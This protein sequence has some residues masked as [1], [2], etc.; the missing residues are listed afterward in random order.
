MVAACAAGRHDNVAKA[1]AA[2]PTAHLALVMIVR[3]RSPPAPRA[4]TGAPSGANYHGSIVTRLRAP[5][6]RDEELLAAESPAVASLDSDQARLARAHSEMKAG[7]DA[8]AGLGPAVSLFGSAR[9]PPDHPDYELALRTARLLGEAGYAVIT[10]GGPGIME[11]GNRGAR[12]AG[13]RSVGLN[14]E[15]PFEQDSNP[16][17]D[18]QLTF[19]YFFTRKLMF[20]RYAVGFVVFPGGFGTLDELFEAL[21]LIQT[22]KVRDFPLLLVGGDYWEGMV[23]WLSER[24]LATGNVGPADLGLMRVTDDPDAV[25]AAVRAGAE[26]QGLAA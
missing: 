24:V 26:R 25:V 10:G 22:G 16:Y 15:L 4:V 13:V 18:L 12:E 7:F 23:E 11:A 20:V 3:L 19:H 2:A 9:T 1:L 21:T 5:G 14:I 6:T 8:L 17:A